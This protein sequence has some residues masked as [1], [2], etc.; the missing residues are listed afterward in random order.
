MAKVL[1]IITDSNIGGAG[2]HM[3]TLLDTLDKSFKAEVILPENSRLAPILKSKHIPYHEV[4]HIDARS[5]SWAGVRAIRRKLKVIKPDIVHTHASLS[6]RIAA[7]RYGRC[8]IVHT[9]HSAYPVPKW[10]KKFPVKL[11]SG[12]ISNTYSDRMIAVSSAAKDVLLDMGASEKKIRVILNGVPRTREFLPEEIATLRDKYDIPQNAFVVAYIARL[13]KIKGHD[14][15]LDAAR[16]L[17]FNVII[18]FAGDGEYENELKSRIEKEQLTNVRMLGFIEEVDEIVAIMDV[19][20]NASYVSEAT[21]LSLLFGMRAGKPAIVTDFSGNPYVIEDGLNGLLVPTCSPEAFDDAITRLK[22]DKGLYNKL[23]EG[24][25]LRYAEQFTAECM[26]V[27]TENVYR[28]L[29]G[30]SHL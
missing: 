2:H 6:G 1:H 25:K 28:E 18:L 7:R 10:R 12:M 23:S 16:E 14:Y 22:D 26:T 30:M 15:I 24:A 8:K 20:V 5:F 4:P 19:Q 11:L 29:L 17:P 3:L 9:M 21:S 13:S 27:A